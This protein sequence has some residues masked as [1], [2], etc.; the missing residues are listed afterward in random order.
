MWLTYLL[1]YRKWRTFSKICKDS[2]DLVATSIH[3]FIK[4]VME[5]YYGSKS[6]CDEA[7]KILK[8]IIKILDKKI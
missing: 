7:N 1:I 2:L 6:G 8:K 4:M 3:P 5:H